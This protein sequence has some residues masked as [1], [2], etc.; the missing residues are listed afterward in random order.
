MREQKELLR[1]EAGGRAG[2]ESCLRFVASH[3]VVIYPVGLR[4]LPRGSP[5]PATVARGLRRECGHRSGYG[6]QEQIGF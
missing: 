6:A 2:H 3:N 4:F 5:P 1:S